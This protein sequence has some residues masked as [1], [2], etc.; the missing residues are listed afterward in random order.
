[1]D[2]WTFQDNFLLRLFIL[3]NSERTPFLH[4]LVSKET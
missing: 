1:M 4:N 3:Y 2:I